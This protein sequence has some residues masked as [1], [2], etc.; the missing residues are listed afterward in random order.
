MIKK[1][2][3]KQVKDSLFVELEKLITYVTV[4]HSHFK[5]SLIPNAETAKHSFSV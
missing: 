2:P 4:S 5:F 3:F 1:K